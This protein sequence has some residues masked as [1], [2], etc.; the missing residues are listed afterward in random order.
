V[1]YE[2]LVDDQVDEGK[3]LITGLVDDGFDVSV[4]FWVKTSEEG[5]WFLYIGST[6]MR[7]MSLA[8]AYRAVYGVIRRI[9]STRL[10]LSNVKLVDPD[11][12][13]AKSA[14]EIRDRYPARL[15]SRYHGRRLGNMT[16]EEAYLYPRAGFMTRT[17][18]LQTVTGLMNRTGVLAPSL[19]TLRD[20]TQIQAVPVGIQMN[21]PGAIQVVFLDLVAS[22]NRSIPVDDVVGIM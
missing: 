22:A 19:V 5:F 10:S 20:G 1:D 18:V 6:S 2:L 4:A 13:I 9:P 16:I 15:P 12:P 14:R 8:D 7:T 21:N 3:S 11:N 17:E